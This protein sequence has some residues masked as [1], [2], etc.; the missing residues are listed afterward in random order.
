MKIFDSRSGWSTKTNFVD[1]NNVFVG[2]DI[3]QSCCEHADW[4]IADEITPS[5]P[6][7]NDG[8]KQPKD[9][10]GYV[11]DRDFFKD[12]S[13]QVTDPDYSY[14]DYVYNPLDAG[15]MVVFRLTSE[16]GGVKYLHIFNS[17]NGYYSHGFSFGEGDN[18]I[19]EDYL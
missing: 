13:D 6:D 1:D 3:E 8:S 4:F 16:K 18:I 14:N 12:I 10:P 11:F 19:M 5:L 15:R 9:L 2:Y 7:Q 17:H